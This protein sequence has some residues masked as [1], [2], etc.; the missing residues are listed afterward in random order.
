M[1]DDLLQDSVEGVTNAL[2]VH[3]YAREEDKI[4]VKPG[5]SSGIEKLVL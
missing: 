2:E 4:P 3:A 1:V 5:K